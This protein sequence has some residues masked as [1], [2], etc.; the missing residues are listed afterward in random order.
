M[1]FFTFIDL[2]DPDPDLA[3]TC[4]ASL[5]KAFVEEGIKKAANTSEI[6]RNTLLTTPILACLFFLY[7]LA[8]CHST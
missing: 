2:I 6:K 4:Q 5:L 7:K 1:Q 3:Y 8:I